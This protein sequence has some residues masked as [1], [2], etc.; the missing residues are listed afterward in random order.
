CVLFVDSNRRIS[1]LKGTQKRVEATPQ[2]KSK[3][4]HP[5]TALTNGRGGTLPPMLPMAY[6]AEGHLIVMGDS[7]HSEIVRALQASEILM[8][9]A[10]EKYPG[11]G[12]ALVEFAWSP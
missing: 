11:P 9:V 3:F 7:A 10:D 8:Q 2:L 4:A 6:Q 5:W 1:V 12:K